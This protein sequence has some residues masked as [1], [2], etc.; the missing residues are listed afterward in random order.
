VIND[1]NT[2]SILSIIVFYLIVA[3]SVAPQLSLLFLSQ[4]YQFFCFAAKKSAIL[5]CLTKLKHL[6]HF[7]ILY[8]INFMVI[9]KSMLLSCPFRAKAIAFI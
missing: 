7:F 2:K 5:S 1:N 4:R 9:F 8:P 3:V 6:L